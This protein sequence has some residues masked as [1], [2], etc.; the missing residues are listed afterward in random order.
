MREALRGLSLLGLLDARLGEGTFIA[1]DGEK[2]IGKMFEWRILT[3][4]RDIENLL[5][6]RLALESETAYYA[7]SRGTDDHF[8]QLEEIINKMQSAIENP[9]GFAPLDL[10]FHLI[11]ARASDNEIM[12]ELLMMIRG[13]LERSLF[14]VLSIPG[15]GNLALQQHK[16]IY[17]AIRKR[18]PEG[19]KSYM[20]EHIKSAL[21]RYKKTVT[22]AV[23]G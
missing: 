10:E 6:V 11:I 7:A 3:E 17:E 5:E 13:Q 21:E 19:A 22:K 12:H 2:F 4:R 9:K 20:R 16:K 18:D 1:E 14:K 23:N 15:G 8:Q